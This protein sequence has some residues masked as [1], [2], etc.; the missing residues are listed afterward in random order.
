M[1][2]SELRFQRQP[3]PLPGDFK[4]SEVV[5]DVHVRIDTPSYVRASWRT[6]EEGDAFDEAFAAVFHKIGFTPRGAFFYDES[7]EQRLHAHPNDISGYISLTTMERLL[8]EM[9]DVA[10]SRVRWVDIYGAYYL[11]TPEEIQKRVKYQHDKLREILFQHCQ[12]SRRTTFVYIR[13]FEAIASHLAGLS[14]HYYSSHSSERFT[15]RSKAILAVADEMVEEGLLA[16]LK[17]ESG[18]KAYRA[19][20]NTEMEAMGLAAPLAS[21]QYAF[22]L[23]T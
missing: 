19:R 12:T 5:H 22:A 15:A 6:S 14:F 1:P 9:K 2:M 18:E 16:A 20:N 17:T 8:D 4:L 10:G 7:G 11:I 13:N 21:R 23:S 3:D